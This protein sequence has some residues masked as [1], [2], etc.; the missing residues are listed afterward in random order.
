VLS[1]FAVSL[2]QLFVSSVVVSLYRENLIETTGWDR[3]SGS[4]VG[5]LYVS[6][7]NPMSAGLTRDSLIGKA[8][9]LVRSSL[10]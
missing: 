7:F 2:V 8:I 1:L 9:G 10:S 4:L 6:K 5:L 3:K